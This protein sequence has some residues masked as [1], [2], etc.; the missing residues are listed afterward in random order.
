MAKMSQTTKEIIKTAIFL[1]VVGAIVYVYG[2][3]PLGASKTAM[4]R[5]DLDSFEELDSLPVNDPTACL[6]MGL[7]CDTFRVESDGITN[8]AAL[9]IETTADTGLPARGTVFLLHSDTTD[10][11]SMLP[12]A[13]MF[14]EGGY[15][16]VLYDQRAAGAST[17]EYHGEGRYEASDLEEVIAWLDL[18]D[19]ITSPVLAVGK[20]LGADAAYLASLEEP[21]IDAVMAI[22]PY[23]STDRMWDV[24]RE[25]HDFWNFPFFKGMMWWWYNKRSSYAAPYR[26]VS[27]IEAVAV[28]TLIYI[29]AD[30]LDTEEIKALKDL[31][32]DDLLTVRPTQTEGDMAGA[33]FDLLKRVATG[34]EPD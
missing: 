12:W 6:D 15:N 21:R 29:D 7:N 23:L 14:S 33:A 16:V 26:E 28:P 2:I 5:Q 10:R 3:Y 8:L 22:E 9:Y 27:D 4:A 11:S 30:A 18:R 19:M 24:K 34:P 32:E 17:N 13:A 31:S 1:I 25:R 20:H